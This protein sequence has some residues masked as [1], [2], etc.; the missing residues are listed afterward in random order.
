MAAAPDGLDQSA[1]DRMERS[2]GV[3]SR[4]LR[5]NAPVYGATRGFGPLVDFPADANGD[6]HGLGLINHLSAGQGPDLDLETTRLML[7]LRLDGMTR[8]FSG[9]P[10]ERWSEIA[11]VLSA[12]FIPVVPAQGSVSAS[13]DLIPLAHAAAAMAGRG[14]AWRSR[15]GGAPVKVPADEQLAHLSLKPIVWGA[16]EALAFVNGTSASL[17]ASLLNHDRLLELTRVAARLTGT[18]VDL[19]RCNAEPYDN[20]VVEAAGGSRGHRM[21]SDWIREQLRDPR[22]AHSARRLQEPYSLR[23]APQVIGAVLDFLQT[24]GSLLERDA[25]GCSDNPVVS[26]SGIFHAGNFYA[27]TA[28]LASDQ[29]SVLV[30]QIAFM[31]E[32]QLAL[33]LSPVGNGG[34]APLLAARPGATSGLAG[35]QLATTALLAEVR[36]K[37]IP[38]TTT[39][40]PT[41]LDNQDIV[42]MALMGALRVARQVELAALILGSL[43]LAVGQLAQELGHRPFARRPWLDRIVELSP[44]LDGDRPLS[45]EVRNVTELLRSQAGG[46]STP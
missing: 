28:G 32:R 38:A 37:C 16:R 6:Q 39:P 3:L 24:S 33:I 25:A 44:R 15:P 18:V 43:G 23:C 46:E 8:G 2:A 19:L 9:I 4:A 42:P 40:V 7:K 22:D 20:T 21:A 26:P 14:M 36:Q 11:V 1:L 29:H 45:E 10:P 35:V 5:E 17:A 12:G 41:N 27:A 30:H 31:A 34:L 13:G